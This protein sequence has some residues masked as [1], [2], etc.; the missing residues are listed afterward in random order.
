MR[1]ELYAAT[2][3]KPT[4][5]S[6]GMK[7]IGS[8]QKSM[9]VISR[10]SEF[11]GSRA[12]AR[13]SWIPSGNKSSNPQATMMSTLRW[14]LAEGAAHQQICFS[15]R[16]QTSHPFPRW[17]DTDAIAAPA[18]SRNPRTSSKSATPRHSDLGPPTGSRGLT[19]DLMATRRSF[20]IT[21]SQTPQG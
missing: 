8:G 19:R 3:S 20:G 4:P 1:K 13:K 16:C 11:G 14:P 9:K 18:A 7:Q 6:L 10:V 21:D 15:I 2:D 17:S 12:N 5:T